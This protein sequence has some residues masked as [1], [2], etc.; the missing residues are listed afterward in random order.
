MVLNKVKNL[1]S[2]EVLNSI[3][4][5]NFGF[6][7]SVVPV[8]N[9]IIPAQFYIVFFGVFIFIK[10]LSF[11]DLRFDKFITFLLILCV[12]LLPALLIVALGR[13]VNLLFFSKHFLFAILIVCFFGSSEIFK[14]ERFF[15]LINFLMLIGALI[16]FIY[17]ILGGV[18]LFEV[19]NP[20][21]RIA[22]GYLTTTTL[23]IYN[24]FI[25]P[26]GFY[27][28]P[29]ALSFFA[30]TAVLL[31]ILLGYDKSP[32]GYK[33]NR[34]LLL[35][36]IVS[37]SAFHFFV[38]L[39]FACYD[40]IFYRN[41]LF[42]IFILSIIIPVYFITNESELISY[43]S[44]RLFFSEGSSGRIEGMI[45]FYNY[46]KYYPSPMHYGDQITC[47]LSDQIGCDFPEWNFGPLTLFAYLG[48]ASLPYYIIIIIFIFAPLF[49]AKKEYFLVFYILIL[50]L[51]QRPYIFNIG[52]SF[53]FSIFLYLL[54]FP[55]N[56]KFKS[57]NNLSWASK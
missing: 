16:G 11:K 50:A 51:L 35:L 17:A 37:M 2:L 46:F 6:L 49:I 20:D 56:K 9:I 54:I 13:N 24:S 44:S 26:S 57:N 39:I 45:D 7:I 27:D 55:L 21:G 1:F 23:S 33:F 52:Y 10:I 32:S 40:F 8:I 53:I 38:V 18:S 5:I 19:R 12:A 22:N 29:G 48:L 14:F 42:L 30:T 4:F 31:R 41:K 34:F 43:I 25:R 47:L 15:T 3:Y 36:G 28:E